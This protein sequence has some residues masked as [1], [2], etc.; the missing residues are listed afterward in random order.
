VALSEIIRQLLLARDQTFTLFGNV[1]IIPD[2]A[3]GTGAA[4]GTTALGS[5]I[6]EFTG[7]LGIAQSVVVAWTYTLLFLVVT[8]VI[9]YWVVTRIGNSPF[10]RVLKAIREDEQVIEAYLGGCRRRR[11]LHCY[12]H[13][14]PEA[15]RLRQRGLSVRPV[16]WMDL[17]PRPDTPVTKHPQIKMRFGTRSVIRREPCRHEGQRSV[18]YG[19]L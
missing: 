19:L 17:S 9:F 12:S 7:G 18:S 3:L 16:A 10:G 1:G 5:A 11:R 8:L 15:L 14:P 4:E 13:T 6:F 2:V